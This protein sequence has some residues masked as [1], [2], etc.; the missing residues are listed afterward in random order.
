MK[1]P[2][3]KQDSIVLVEVKLVG[4][5]GIRRG[6]MALD[7]GSTFV[8]APWEVIESPGYDPQVVKKSYYYYCKFH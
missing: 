1:I 7:T 4:T 3:Y 2:L 6:R 5:A 8:I